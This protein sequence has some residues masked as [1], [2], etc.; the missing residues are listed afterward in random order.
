[1]VQDVPRVIDAEK[2]ATDMQHRLQTGMRTV[3]ERSFSLARQKDGTFDAGVLSVHSC[4]H[5]V[6]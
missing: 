2:L 1:M 6:R 3:A 4:I 5:I